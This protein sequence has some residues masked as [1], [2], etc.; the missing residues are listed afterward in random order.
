MIELKKG[1]VWSGFTLR[2]KRR[3][4]YVVIEVANECTC[5]R[6]DRGV[7]KKWVMVSLP[8]VNLPMDWFSGEDNTLVDEMNL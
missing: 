2:T 8:K 5:R 3:C 1:Q 6:V 7:W 4:F